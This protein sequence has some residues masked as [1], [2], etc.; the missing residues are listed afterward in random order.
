MVH[1]DAA[2]QPRGHREEVRAVLPRHVVR[3]DQ[4]QIGLVDER[5]RLEAVPDALAGHA[6]PRDLV[7]LVMDE[8]NQLLEGGFIALAPREEERRHLRWR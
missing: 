8:R 6:A 3:I 5:R 2:H 1:Q 4:P 7:E